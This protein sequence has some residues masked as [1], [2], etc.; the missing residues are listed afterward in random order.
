MTETA[1][2]AQDNK[3]DY[4]PRNCTHTALRRASRQLSQLYDD[5]LAPAGLTA[6]QSVL[7][8]RIEGLGGVPGGQGPTL[9]ALAGSLSMQLSALT[10]ALRPLVRDGIVVLAPDPQDGRSKRAV[11]TLLGLERT[12]VMYKLWVEMNRRIDAVLGEGQSEALRQLSVMVADPEFA[13]RVA[14]IA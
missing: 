6:A 9:Q 1:S 7:T 13:R 2:K 11:L 3:V 14:A 4:D 5:A 10:H 8:S 12:Q